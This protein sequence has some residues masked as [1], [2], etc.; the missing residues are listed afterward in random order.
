[1]ERRIIYTVAALFAALVTFSCRQAPEEKHT[2]FETITLAPADLEIP[3]DFSAAIAGRNDVSIM[4]QTS[5]QL[6]TVCVAP[7]QKV[8]KGDKLFVIDSRKADQMLKAVQA[9]LSAALAQCSSAELEYKS[10]KNLYEKKIVS[11]YML[12]TSL[13]DYNR[14]LAAVEQA[15]AA[16]RNAQLNLDFCTITSPV[17]GVVGDINNNPGDQVSEMTLLTVISGNAEMKA[18]FSIAENLLKELVE[19]TGS[20]ESLVAELPE[21]SLILKGGTE[22]P[23]KGKVRHIS[24]VVDKTTGSLTLEAFFPNPDGYL[25]SGIQGTVRL[26]SSYED[27]LVAPVSSLVRVQDKAFVYK[28]KD[29]CAQSAVVE[30]AELGNGKDVALLSGVSEGDVI[31]A[32]GAVNVYEGQQVVFPEES[33]NGKK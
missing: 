8:R 30:F 5:G 1:M 13:N 32:S 2:S 3:Y 15:K 9:D 22:Y 19:A 33:R 17:D 10:N 14:A 23:Y 18:S 27:V 16:L 6:M 28:V 31:V 24:G 11:E 4:P 7:G 20:L 21:A 25:F 26:M 12:N 29:N